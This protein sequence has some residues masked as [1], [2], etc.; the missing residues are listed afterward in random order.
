MKSRTL[1]QQL[2]QTLTQGY[3]LTAGIPARKSKLHIERFEVA[4][5]AVWG[6][7]LA[8]IALIWAYSTKYHLPFLQNWKGNADAL[9]GVLVGCLF[10][11]LSAW[12]IDKAT[13]PHF[14]RHN[15]NGIRKIAQSFRQS[16]HYLAFIDAR[17]RLAKLFLQETQ[18][19]RVLD[20]PILA[21]RLFEMRGILERVFRRM[22]GRI[23]V[24]EKLMDGVIAK[25]GLEK[26]RQE[27]RTLVGAAYHF[28]ILNTDYVGGYYKEAII[29][30]GD[31]LEFGIKPPVVLLEPEFCI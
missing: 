19:Q 16:Y 6:F 8:G 1:T 9:G 27:L 15:R 13:L 4:S 28:N 3:T 25:Q 30:D 24:R 31:W 5:L 7:M 26:L 22:A 20:K 17:N 12:Y 21:D 11:V 23:L 18:P 2:E 14:V 10:L 29:L